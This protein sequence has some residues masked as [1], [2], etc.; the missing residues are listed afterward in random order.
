[1]AIKQNQTKLYYQLL[2][3]MWSN[4]SSRSL[5]VGMQN[6]IATVK[7]NLVVYFNAN[8]S[9]T[10]ESINWTSRYLLTEVTCQHKK[11]HL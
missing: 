1:M 10:I 7:D 3:N 6:G 8:H 11:L 2:A 9:L 5:L 4:G